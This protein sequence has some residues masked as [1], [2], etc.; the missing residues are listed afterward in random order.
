LRTSTRAG[1]DRKVEDG[2]EF[3]LAGHLRFAADPLIRGRT[4]NPTVVMPEPAVRAEHQ[5]FPPGEMLIEHVFARV[6]AYRCG[7]AATSLSAGFALNRLL[8]EGLGL[9][10]G[11]ALVLVHVSTQRDKNPEQ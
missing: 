4:P 8:T 10:F 9:L 3:Q 5:V 1:A 7:T 11:L 2:S 6:T